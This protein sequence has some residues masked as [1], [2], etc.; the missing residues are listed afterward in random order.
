MDGVKGSKP[1]FFVWER[2]WS[3]ELVY[4]TLSSIFSVVMKVH[5][6]K[7]STNSRAVAN[8]SQLFFLG[9]ICFPSASRVSL[10]SS[11]SLGPC[12]TNLPNHLIQ[13][14]QP[15]PG[16]LGLSIVAVVVVVAAAAAAMA[17]IIIDIYCCYC[18][19]IT[20]ATSIPISTTFIM[21]LMIMTIMIIFMIAILHH[22]HSW[23]FLALL[24]DLH[25]HESPHQAAPRRARHPAT[26]QQGF[27]QEFL[28]AAA[29]G[30]HL[31]WS[32]YR[33]Y[34]RGYVYIYIYAD[35]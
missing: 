7:S 35:R 3:T 15:P 34:D 25:L 14:W 22:Y 28:E 6:L 10:A 13:G 8:R 23:F 32:I 4:C 33:A 20:T 2:C 17:T 27:A 30:C 26:V 18:Y 1:P 16:L 19:I 24:A 31:I 11:A 12:C 21:I 29:W 9:L 5:F